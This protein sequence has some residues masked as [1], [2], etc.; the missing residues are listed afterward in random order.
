M[1][2][3]IIFVPFVLSVLVQHL[4]MLTKEEA[5]IPTKPRR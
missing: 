5:F 2:M 1:N 4:I 3:N